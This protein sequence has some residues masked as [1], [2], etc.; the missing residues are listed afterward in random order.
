M[1]KFFKKYY[2]N[3]EFY[4]TVFYKFYE[5]NVIVILSLQKCIFQFNIEM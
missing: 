1:L 4:N 3:F 5:Q 2:L